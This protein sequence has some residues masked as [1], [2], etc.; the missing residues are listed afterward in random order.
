MFASF[1]VPV[2]GD[3]YLRYGDA[4][5]SNSPTEAKFPTLDRERDLDDPTI[6]ADSPPCIDLR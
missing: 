3:V 2:L 6:V 1:I 5:E 4:T